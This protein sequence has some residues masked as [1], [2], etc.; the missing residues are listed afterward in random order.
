MENGR[1]RLLL[2]NVLRAVQVVDRRGASLLQAAEQRI[3]GMLG[4]NGIVGD[5]ACRR[6]D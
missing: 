5:Q 3:Q 2:E 4:H 1:D 6:N